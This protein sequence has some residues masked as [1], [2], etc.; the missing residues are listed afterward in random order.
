MPS[1]TSSVQ[2]L[3]PESGS[4]SQDGQGPS[5]SAPASPE[6][7]SKGPQSHPADS[8]SKASI[9]P[10]ATPSQID[11]LPTP[12]RTSPEAG[13][14]IYSTDNIVTP[15]SQGNSAKE[16]TPTVRSSPLPL[17]TDF[18]TPQPIAT[19]AGHTIDFSPKD[20]NII[21]HGTI[22]SF[23][24]QTT[25]IPT[26]SNPRGPA[27]EPLGDHPV[28]SSPKGKPIV[29]GQPVGSTSLP[30]IVFD[31]SLLPDGPAITISGTPVSLGSSDLVVGSSTIPLHQQ[32][33]L[34][35][36]SHICP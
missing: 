15:A 6:D 8:P 4:T 31:Q 21:V 32:T 17:H 3:S 25:A 24:A 20:S 14:T 26:A 27:F 28:S 18:Q 23:G 35:A 30:V 19:V 12:Q 1:S 11:D 34:A 9:A 10:I 22:S 16:P 33:P 13:E 2:K 29:P 5:P 7:T 36:I